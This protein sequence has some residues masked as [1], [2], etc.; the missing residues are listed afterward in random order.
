MGTRVVESLAGF[1]LSVAEVGEGAEGA[2]GVVAGHL[3]D[4]M[5]HRAAHI[6]ESARDDSE[7]VRRLSPALRAL[8]S[9]GSAPPPP[10]ATDPRYVVWLGKVT[11]AS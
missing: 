8:A 11:A 7:S 1:A 6:L 4:Q 10:A 2:A 9:P 5:R 3:A